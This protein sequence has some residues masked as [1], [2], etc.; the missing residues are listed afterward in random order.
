MKEREERPRNGK[1]LDKSV[2]ELDA[3]EREISHKVTA[4]HKFGQKGETSWTRKFFLAVRG[5]IRWSFSGKET[6][7]RDRAQDKQG[8]TSS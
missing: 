4:V 2:V 3:G 6:H 8:P 5:I 7:A 1:Q